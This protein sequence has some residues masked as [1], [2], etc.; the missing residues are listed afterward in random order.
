MT[1]SKNISEE[2]NVSK[3]TQRDFWPLT[4]LLIV[5]IALSLQ[6]YWAFGWRLPLSD[7]IALPV[8]SHIAKNSRIHQKHDIKYFNHDSLYFAY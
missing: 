2:N 6:A 7:L 5:I 1:N 4:R 3:G 8:L